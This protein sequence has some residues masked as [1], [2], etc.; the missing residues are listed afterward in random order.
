MSA[1]LTLKA[2]VPRNDFVWDS[3][4]W[5]GDGQ[6]LHLPSLPKQPGQ[7]MAVELRGLAFEKQTHMTEQTHLITKMTELEQIEK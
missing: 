1:G 6:L 4:R 5:Y 2:T 7:V 3:M